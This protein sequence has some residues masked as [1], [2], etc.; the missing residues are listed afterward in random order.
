M[1][2]NVE[3]LRV[4]AKDVV[5]A[6]GGRKVV[7]SERNPDHPK[8]EVFIVADGKT[9]RVAVTK[10]VRRLLGEGVL[11]EAKAVAEKITPEKASA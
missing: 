7:L 8:G 9:H 10:A 4:T 11:R 2:E 3:Y 5:A 6:D 1:A